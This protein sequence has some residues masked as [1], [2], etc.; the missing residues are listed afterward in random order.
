MIGL[1]ERRP[2][3][4]TVVF[5]PGAGLSGWMWRGP[6]EALPELDAVALDPPGHGVSSG[7]PW[8]S[9][10]ATAAQVAQWIR[11]NATGGKAH[12]VGLSLGG[13]VA[14]EIAARHPEVVDRLVTTGA[15]GLGV[16]AVEW[17]AWF[18]EVTTPLALRLSGRFLGLTADERTAL[19]GDIERLPRGFMRRAV[20]ELG[21]CRITPAL[22]ANPIPALVVAG[23]REAA[24][25]RQ[26]VARVDA[27]W[28][29]AEGRLV[30]DGRHA[31]NFQYRDRFDEMLRR[32]LLDHEVAPWLRRP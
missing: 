18:M 16:P 29:T 1:A 22:M 14:L 23:T 21:V 32:W 28:P 27:E 9:I 25:I 10:P 31:W 3:R 7:Q 2:G 12:V 17:L 24:S 4:P 11:T 8:E 15:A 20:R 19:A 26:A 13:V 30:V 5:L 6:I